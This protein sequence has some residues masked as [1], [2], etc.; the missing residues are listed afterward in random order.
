MTWLY[1]YVS[2]SILFQILLRDRL[3]L[4]QD[5]DG[6]SLGHTAGPCSLSI[7]HVAVC[8]CSSQI[9]NLS[10]PRFPFSKQKFVFCVCETDN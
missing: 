9:P 2:I 5:T 7:L 8:I 4:V 3:L 1:I 10:L 6:S